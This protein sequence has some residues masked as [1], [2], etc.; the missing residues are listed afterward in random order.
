MTMEKK[1]NHLN[2]ALKVI[3]KKKHQFDY[4]CLNITIGNTHVFTC[5]QGILQP[6][7]YICFIP[8]Q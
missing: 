8:S 2:Y 6:L 3:Q 7:L 1:T 4:D 5:K